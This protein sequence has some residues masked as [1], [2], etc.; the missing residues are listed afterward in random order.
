MF[1]FGIG[2]IVF[3][4]LLGIA[5]LMVSMW[6]EL[7][8]GVRLAGLM[9]L[10]ELQEIRDWYTTSFKELRAFHFSKPNPRSDDAR[11]W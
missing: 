7:S 1:F 6:R 2:N 5:H 11:D 8:N 3:M 4:S 9:V 10:D